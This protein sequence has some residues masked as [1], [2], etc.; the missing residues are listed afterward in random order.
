[1][2]R[3]DEHTM[4]PFTLKSFIGFVLLAV[5]VTAPL[6]WPRLRT[7]SAAPHADL[8]GNWV[9]KVTITRSVLGMGSGKTMNQP[10]MLYLTMASYDTFLNKVRGEGRLCIAGEKGG[11]DVHISTLGPPKPDG[12][13]SGMIT[14]D[15]YA[16]ETPESLRVP[17]A[18]RTMEGNWDGKSLTLHTIDDGSTIGY[19]FEATL[20]RGA[21]DDFV[22]SC[23]QMQDDK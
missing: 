23:K 6:W 20:H 21:Q 14:G 22:A 3:T 12:H 1:V 13:L 16:D 4:T 17:G 15:L 7:I 2:L 19:V 9:G 8:G 11:R 10:A 18:G 5:L